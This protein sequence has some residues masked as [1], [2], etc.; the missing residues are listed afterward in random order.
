[1]KRFVLATLS[2]LA[3]GLV[4]D[5]A[6]LYAQA[7]DLLQDAPATVPTPVTDTLDA[8]LKALE[9]EV[10]A[11][12]ARPVPEIKPAP[13]PDPLGMS[14]K[15]NNGLELNSNNKAFKIHIGGRTQVDSVFY[16]NSNSFNNTGGVTDQDSVN[17]RR[18][19]FRMDG[20]MYEII[21]FAFEY[22][23]A[24]QFNVN[25]PAPSSSEANYA[26]VPAVTDL[27]INFKQVPIVGNIK[28]GNFKDPLGMEH[29]TSSRYLEFMERSVIQDLFTGSFNNGFTPGIQAWDTFDGEHG[30]WATGF[31]KNNTNIFANGQ[32]DGEY[33]WTSRL[34]YLP[35][36]EDNGDVL[37]HVGIAGSIRDPNNGTLRYRARP[38]L[39]NGP[40]SG[41]NPIFVDT[42]TFACSQ[43]D[44]LG[45]ELAGNYGAFSFQSEYM[46]SWS[47]N[48][49]SNVGPLAGM[50]VGTASV[51]SWYVEGLYFLTGETRPYDRK[52][53]VFTRIVP[54]ENFQFGKGTGAWQVAAR[55]SRANL[56]DPGI[57]GGQ[58]Q[59]ATLGLNWFLNPNV[60]IQTNYVWAY[61]N[62]PIYG[63]A[64][65]LNGVAHGVG[66]RLAID[67]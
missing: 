16:Q 58:M 35:I 10:Q 30:T 28:V 11:L 51:N 38:S 7:P 24:N 5:P 37:L 33:S 23:F 60:K 17:L 44:L 12:R 34:T 40:P 9:L 45:A 57:N 54:Q 32:G 46:N 8:R 1:M 21:D 39:R 55:Y 22:D 29:L 27:W 14:A 31:F 18:A 43:Q 47:Q 64:R 4:S 19:R 59:D 50:N 61:G 48:T 65:G 49:I 26:A 2:L 20:T 36:Y 52:A 6:S 13:T 25:P 42:G 63:T 56:N 66:T 67:F 3:C 15:W 62:Q 53:G 41:L